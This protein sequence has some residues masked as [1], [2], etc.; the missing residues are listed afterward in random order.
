M[1]DWTDRH[2]RYFHRLLAP[3]AR[4]YTEMVTSLV[5]SLGLAPV[6]IVAACTGASMALNYTLQNPQKVR[7]LFLFHI[8]T[9]TSSR[10]GSLENMI[11]LLGGRP[12]LRRMLIPIAE[13]VMLRKRF[14]S[15]R[16]SSI[17]FT[18]GAAT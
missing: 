2:C 1:M 14:V 4:L 9:P 7:R 6:T 8:A 16:A 13:K 5:D 15:P 11:R 18:R 3:H 12:G 10:N 17:R